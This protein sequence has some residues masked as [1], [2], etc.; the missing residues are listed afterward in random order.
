MQCINSHCIQYGILA[1]FLAAFEAAGITGGLVFIV[2]ALPLP[3]I[4]V[5][6]ASGHLLWIVFV[7]NSNF[8][9]GD[10]RDST[11]IQTLVADLVLLAWSTTLIILY[12]L[13]PLWL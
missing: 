12:L 10:E 2:I 13:N 3:V 1:L 4:G 6:F 11:F 5:F 7:R 9:D 8:D